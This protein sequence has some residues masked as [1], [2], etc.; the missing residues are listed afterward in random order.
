MREMNS[1]NDLN[2]YTTNENS[3]FFNQQKAVEAAV[4]K[5]KSKKNVDAQFAVVSFDTQAGIET[6]WTKDSIKYPTKVG[7][8]PYPGGI[9][10]ANRPVEQIM[11]QD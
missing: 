3:R 7:N 6:E 9:I 4:A 2:D 5:L 8:Y 10:M 1:K 11:K